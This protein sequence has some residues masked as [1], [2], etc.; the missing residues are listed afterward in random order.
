MSKTY[1]SDLRERVVAQVNAG[2]SCREVARQFG[3]SPSFVIKLMQLVT[4]TGTSAAAKRGRPFGHG[5]LAGVT[6][7]LITRVEALPDTTLA[8]QTEWL[9]REFNVHV[10][11]F[12][13]SRILRSAGFTYKKSL[14]AVEAGRARIRLDPHRL[15]FIGETS[16]TTKMTR[17]RG[18]SLCGE[19][20]KA[21]TAFGHWRTQTFIAGLRCDGLIA[22][23]VLNGPINRDACDTHIETQ[24]A[25]FS[26]SSDVT[27]MSV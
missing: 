2:H 9:A 8:E 24:L 22:P 21:T 3:V 27:V 16:T 10:H 7:A 6:E 1:S 25:S 5:K 13:I 11:L 15:I 17:L 14:L 23:W 12:S 20:L 26:I 18:R 4:K 19:R